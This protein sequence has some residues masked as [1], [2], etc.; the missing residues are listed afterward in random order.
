MVS[1][2]FPLFFLP[3]GKDELAGT[4]NLDILTKK[5][6]PEE[7]LPNSVSYCSESGGGKLRDVKRSGYGCKACDTDAR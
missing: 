7:T 6:T 1:G 5:V 4:L 3:L 2:D